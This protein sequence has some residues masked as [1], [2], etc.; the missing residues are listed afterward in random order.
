MQDALFQVGTQSPSMQCM[1]SVH[2]EDI[3]GPTDEF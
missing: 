2:L 1:L 3:D